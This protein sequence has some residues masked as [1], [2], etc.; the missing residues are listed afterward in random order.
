MRTNRGKQKI[1]AIYTHRVSS[2][3]G[4]ETGTYL[5]KNY[6]NKQVKGT[7]ESG[8]RTEPNHNTVNQTY[9]LTAVQI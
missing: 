5:I 4:T 9:S 6:G 3:T 2:L 8:N 7:Q 1:R